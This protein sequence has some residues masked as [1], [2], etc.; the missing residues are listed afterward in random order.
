MSDPEVTETTVLDRESPFLGSQVEPFNWRLRRV[1]EAR[2]G[3]A[4]RASL[5]RRGVRQRRR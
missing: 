1:R 2:G 4:H 5:A 3:I